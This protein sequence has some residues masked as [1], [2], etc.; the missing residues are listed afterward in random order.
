MRTYVVRPGDSPA[1]IAAEYGFCPKC[2]R[3][4]V[5]AN[6][7]KESRILPNGFVTF[8]SL[9]VGETLNLPTIWDGDNDKRPPE[10]FKS[11]PH[12]DGVRTGVGQ[13]PVGVGDG[14]GVA[15]SGSLFGLVLIGLGVAGGYWYAKRR[16]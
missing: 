8:H 6:P 7:H 14:A 4:L 13:A 11:L 10:Y 9:G 2:A 3:D 16:R 5:A 15:V 1:S 12:P